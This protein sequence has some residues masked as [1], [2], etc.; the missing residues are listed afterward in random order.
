MPTKRKFYKKK[1]TGTTQS[2][3]L[4][5]A[6]SANLQSSSLSSSQRISFTA[7][8]IFAASLYLTFMLAL[9]IGVRY[10]NSRVDQALHQLESE[11][12]AEALAMLKPVVVAGTI[13]D[14]MGLTKPSP[15]VPLMHF[16][17]INLHYVRGRAL[18]ETG[19]PKE[20]ITSFNWV[21]MRL[22]DYWPAHANAASAHFQLDNFTGA[23]EAV[24]EAI[25]VVERAPK[26]EGKDS[27]E[28]RKP[29]PPVEAVYEVGPFFIDNGDEIKA[30]ELTTDGLLAELYL[31]KGVVL[32]ELPIDRCQGGSCREH[33]AIALRHSQ[34]LNIRVSKALEASTGDGDGMKQKDSKALAAAIEA[35]EMNHA[36]A[37]QLLVR[38]T[39]DAESKTASSKAHISDLFDEYAPTF[40]SSLVKDLGYQAF[41]DLR[42]AVQ[43]LLSAAP[44]TSTGGAARRVSSIL[45]VGCGTGLAGKVFRELMVDHEA[46]HTAGRLVGIDISGK[47]AEKARSLRLNGSFGNLVYNEVHVGDL[48]EQIPLLAAA[49]RTRGNI[50]SSG[51]GVIVFAD[52]LIYF[53]DISSVLAMASDALDSKGLLA[54]TL[55]APSEAD[56]EAMERTISPDE[57]SL[58][59]YKWR[60]KL[61]ASGRYSHNPAWVEDIATLSGLT[62]VRYRSLPSLRTERG[63][64]IKGSLFVFE[65][66]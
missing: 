61:E 27:G 49:E 25:A 64:P 39:A 1:A 7:K 26:G 59:E 24:Q 15:F 44:L 55:E 6:F 65:K 21:T 5:S 53:S 17:L 10:C 30:N 66:D 35:R 20:A 9:R 62:M 48:E 50:D 4:N 36:L 22:S 33:A 31:Q 8:I 12:P 52:V 28:Q 29:V 56:R 58:N 40:E 23:L 43:S 37:G 3:D 2:P 41:D 63:I 46:P 51:F 54:L 34:V 32:L 38:A 13:L 16:D 57:N 60:W 18:F 11:N 19:S 42:D 14:Y 47:M 45:D